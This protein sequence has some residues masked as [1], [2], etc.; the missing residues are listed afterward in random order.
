MVLGVSRTV[1]RYL[2]RVLHAYLQGFIVCDSSHMRCVLLLRV[3]SMANMSASS[4]SPLA[5]S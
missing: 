5:A 2:S 4:G 1:S 3:L